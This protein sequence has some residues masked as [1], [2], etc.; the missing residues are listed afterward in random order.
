MVGEA[1]VA[2]AEAVAVEDVRPREPEFP[3]HDSDVGEHTMHRLTLRATAR[4]LL[5]RGVFVLGAIVLALT[6]PDLR[7]IAQEAAQKSFPTPEEG[8]KALLAAVKS[9]DNAQMLAI[10]GPDGKDLVS[11]GD[12][13]ADRAGRD[14]IARAAG[15]MTRLVKQDDSTEILHVGDE[16]WPMPIPL[17]KDTK[18]WRFDTAQGK[19]EILD[20]RIG[21][22]ELT[23]IGVCHAYATAQVEYASEDL[24]GDQVLEFA[25]SLASAP[26]KR[27]GLHWKPGSGQAPSPL[28]PLVAGAVAEGYGAAR[29]ANGPRPYH[30]YL[31]RIL[32]AQGKHAPG[33]AYSYVINGNMIGGFALVAYPVGYGNS[34]IMTFLV[35]QQGIVYQKDLGEQTSEIA[36]AMS[37]YDPDTTWKKTE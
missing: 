25:Q 1:G 29:P 20:R 21:R 37:L 14:N 18:G 30:G 19:E 10:L 4:S 33:G 34:G 11:S 27:D 28:G 6:V 12:A 23:A 31:F 2:A 8:A 32:K 26:G 24:D 15:E 17:V 9:G 3:R 7:A 5:R 16:D 35:N 13:V 22:N 36:G